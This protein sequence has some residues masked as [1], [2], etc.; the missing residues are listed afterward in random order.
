M[1]LSVGNF[2]VVIDVK[3]L[4]EVQNI[5]TH[6]EN[7]VELKEILQVGRVYITVAVFV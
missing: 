3:E 4:I 2:A 7:V 1:L 6:Q 5:P